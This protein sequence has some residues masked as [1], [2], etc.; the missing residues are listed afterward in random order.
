MTREGAIQFL[1]EWGF[2][3]RTSRYHDLGYPHENVIGRIMREGAGASQSSVP[4]DPPIPDGFDM[5][6][7]VVVKM[8][9]LVKQSIYERYV[10]QHSDKKAMS[11][12]GCGRTEYRNRLDRGA[13]FVAGYL[14]AA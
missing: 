10:Y 4:Q 6:N 12:C 9:C 1:K 7:A 2:Y 5:V 3:V 13:M 14:A 11:V 8:E